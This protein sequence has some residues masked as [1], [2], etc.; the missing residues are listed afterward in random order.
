MSEA[1]RVLSRLRGKGLFPPRTHLPPGSFFRVSELQK[2]QNKPRARFKQRPYPPPHGSQP[3]ISPARMYF[4]LACPEHVSAQNVFVL[5]ENSV[6]VLHV[7][8][9]TSPGCEEP[10]P[11][12]SR[13]QAPTCS[14]IIYVF[15]SWLPL[16][17]ALRLCHRKHKYLLRTN[18]YKI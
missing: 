1:L 17:A 4:L 5:G 8:I 15:V 7:S 18:W 12:L 16:N 2:T 10:W 9:P 14:Y 11:N 6:S 3:N 13:K